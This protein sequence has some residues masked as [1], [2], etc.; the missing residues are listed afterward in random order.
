M[1]IRRIGDV[2]ELLRGVTYGKG[3]TT[4]ST[5]ADALPLLRATNITESGLLLTDLVFIPA[6]LAKP[7]Q[8]VRVGDIVMT[9]SS[10]SASVVGR[11]VLVDA[12]LEATF[13]AFCGVLRASDQVLSRYLSYMICAPHVRQWWSDCARG[14]NINNLKREDVLQTEILVP[15]LAEQTRIVA[16][17]DEVG[18]EMSRLEEVAERSREA[19]KDLFHRFVEDRLAELYSSHP[20]R[21][22]GDVLAV[23][24]GGSPRPIAEFLTSSSD[25]INWVKIS[26]ATASRKYIYE[27]A[28][29]IKPEGVSRSRLVS[30]GDFLLSNSM[31]LVGPTSCEQLVVSMTAGLF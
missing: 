22:I 5:A 9:M 30:N 3:D 2:A 1:S 27:T 8:R 6:R 26:D 16:K 19:S 29:K 17:L 25:G 12:S 4:E 13:G 7:E 21:R 23:A 10:G 24:R 11:S 18:A 15:P 20:V 31:S 28:E 14:T